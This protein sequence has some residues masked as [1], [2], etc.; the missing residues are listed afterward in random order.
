[1][2]LENGQTD[3]IL[4]IEEGNLS[5]NSLTFVWFPFDFFAYAHESKKMVYFF[6]WCD[7]SHK[8]TPD[9]PTTNESETMDPMVLIRP[10]KPPDN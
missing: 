4:F 5:L 10:A 1:L 6:L 2:E 9:I 7:L 8:I 3:F